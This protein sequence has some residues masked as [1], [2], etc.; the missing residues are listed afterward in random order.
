MEKDLLFMEK[1]STKDYKDSEGLS[2]G[3]IEKGLNEEPAQKYMCKFF[4]VEEG[5]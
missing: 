2:V 3:Y 5:C 4:S 1:S